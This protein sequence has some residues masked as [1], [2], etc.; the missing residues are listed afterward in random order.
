MGYRVTIWFT[1]QG[2]RLGGWSENFWNNSPDVTTLIPRIQALRTMLVWLK[3]DQTYSPRYRYSEIGVFRSAQTIIV[4]GAAPR[5]A[6][7]MPLAPT[8]AGSDYLTTKIFM[9]LGSANGATQQWFGGQVDDAI[10]DGGY[11]NRNNAAIGNAAQLFALLANSAN[12]WCVNMLP[13]VQVFNPISF[14]DNVTG[15]VTLP[16]AAALPATRIR[17]KGVRGLTAA[18][19]L[20]QVN[21]VA[22]PTVPPTF[23]LRGWTAQ[24]LAPMTKSNNPTWAAQIYALYPINGG[25]FVRSS[26]HRAG[27]PTGQVGGRPKKRKTA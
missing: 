27:R 17:I 22:V 26:N 1:Q 25:G 3:G 7:P 20:W 15:T 24:P 18:N 9:R 4:P 21:Q 6:P 12:G 5:A 10:V 14:I 13:R 19:G 2:D 8:T 11:L 23:V 16:L